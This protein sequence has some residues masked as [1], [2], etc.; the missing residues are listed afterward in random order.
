MKLDELLPRWDARERHE[1]IL[2]ASPDAV[3]RALFA[4]DLAGGWTIR[5]LMGLRALPALLFRSSTVHPAPR[6]VGLEELIAFGFGRLAEVSGEEIALG[7]EG[8]FWRP[9]GNLE[10]FD[11]RRFET[12]VGAGRARAV[13]NFTVVGAGEGK[14]RL[15]T[16]TRVLCGD[17]ASR[18]KFRLYWLLVRP[19][20]GWIRRAM[21]AAV[22][23][24]CA[25]GRD[26]GGA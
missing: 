18:R 3:W 7:I 24:E 4:A 10:P 5:L 14:S 25:R 21:L 23:R 15:A 13:W 8:R 6:R 26:A 22:A 12:P 1:R 11:R 19:G 20:S 16:E 2:A 9:L 17:P